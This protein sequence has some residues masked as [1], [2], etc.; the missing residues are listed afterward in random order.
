MLLFVN[1]PF[2]IATKKEAMMPRKIS[3]GR[4]RGHLPLNGDKLMMSLAIRQ[5]RRATECTFPHGERQT[6]KNRL[7]AHDAREEIQPFVTS[8]R[9]LV[10]HCNRHGV[11]ILVAA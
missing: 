5:A 6:F 2:R 1:V 9:T 7:S 8:W 3:K 4:S 11:Y 10:R